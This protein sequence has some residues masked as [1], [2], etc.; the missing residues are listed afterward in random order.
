[1]SEK[2]IVKAMKAPVGDY[3]D[4]AAIEAWARKITEALEKGKYDGNNS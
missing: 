2:L 1:M 3:R 4:W